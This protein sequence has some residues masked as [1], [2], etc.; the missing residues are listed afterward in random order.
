MAILLIA[1]C[2]TLLSE[3]QALIVLVDSLVY[4]KESLY[5]CLTKQGVAT[6]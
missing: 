5:T 3:S 1:F 2:N 6:K 4:D